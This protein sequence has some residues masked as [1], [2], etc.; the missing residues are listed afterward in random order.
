MIHKEYGN[1]TKVFI[2]KVDVTSEKDIIALKELFTSENMTCDIL[3]NN[4]GIVS[5]KALATGDLLPKNA[6]FTMNVNCLSNFLILHHFLP[7]MTS[8][9]KGHVVTI[10]SSMGLIP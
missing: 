6:N 3:I 4:A 2:I 9:N 5:G 7:T 8:N 10:A 1:E